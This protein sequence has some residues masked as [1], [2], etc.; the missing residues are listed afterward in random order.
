MFIL[1]RNFK[2]RSEIAKHFTVDCEQCILDIKTKI[3]YKTGRCI[4]A[5]KYMVNTLDFE[6]LCQEYYYKLGKYCSYGFNVTFPS[7][8]GDI[9]VFPKDLEKYSC[10]NIKLNNRGISLLIYN[11]CNFEIFDENDLLKDLIKFDKNEDFFTIIE[12]TS[13]EAVG[14]I[15]LEEFDFSNLHYWFKREKFDLKELIISKN[16]FSVSEVFINKILGY[17]IIEHQTLDLSYR[18]TVK[19]IIQFLLV[20]NGFKESLLKKLL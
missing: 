10:Q 5:H 7:L 14:Y 1:K 2:N 3:I 19:D 20:K 11:I 17:K 13:T 15:P 12:K 8:N 18:K 9:I 16:L 4:Y 6:N